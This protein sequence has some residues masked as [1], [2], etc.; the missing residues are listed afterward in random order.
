MNEIKQVK[1]LSLAAVVCVLLAWPLIS[2]SPYIFNIMIMTGLHIILATSNRLILRTGT[3]FLGHAAFYAI[4]VYTVL[5]ARQFLGLNYWAALPLAG[6]AAG[7]VAL[8]LGF[9]TAKVRGVPFCIITVALV[10]VVRLTIVRLGGGRPVKCPPPEALFGLDFS[11]KIHYYYFIFALVTLTL[12]ILNRVEKSR[13]GGNIVATAESESL[14]ESVG[15]NTTRYRVV[16][17][18]LSCFFAGIAGGF[19]APYVRVVGYTTFTLTASIVILIYVVVGGGRSLW[20]PV[21]GAAF[22]TILPE[23]LPGRA[24]I[25]NIIYAAVVLGTL[26]FLPGGLITLPRAVLRRDLPTMVQ[27]IKRK[28][29]GTANR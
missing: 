24:A 10:E 11:S 23:F 2:R 21:I 3:W 13:F 29:A 4:G 28:T 18:S 1:T 7:I 15:I 14:A 5:L 12:L 16:I 20:G 19:F 27:V 9:T 17:M 8:V 25:Q 26:F 6:L 22:L